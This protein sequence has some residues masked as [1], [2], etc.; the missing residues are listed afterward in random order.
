MRAALYPASWLI[1]LAIGIAVAIRHRTRLTLFRLD[2]WRWLLA[3]WK[4]ATF[5]I[6]TSG[7]IAIAPLM[8]DPYWDRIDAA[9]MSMLTFLTAPWAVGVLWRALSRKTSTAEVFVALCAVLF[10]A[11]WSFD[12][13]QTIRLGVYPDI[14]QLNLAASS[15]LYVM[16]GVFWNLHWSLGRGVSFAF[17]DSEWPARTI[18]PSFSKIVWPATLLML[19]TSIAV[20]VP[21]V[22]D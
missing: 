15:A 17:L 7:L 11:S 6:A 9:F 22:W 8:H 16:A 19:S 21:F 3:P 14:W 4:L 10:S 20:I 1:V 13:Y 12:A 18:A 5:V 2:Y